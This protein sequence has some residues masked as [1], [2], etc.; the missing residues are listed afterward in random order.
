VAIAAKEIR[1]AFIGDR[2]F[3]FA[4]H[5]ALQ[6]LGHARTAHTAGDMVRR[7]KMTA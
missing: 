5:A 4:F 2:V 3:F 1:R 7:L 6:T